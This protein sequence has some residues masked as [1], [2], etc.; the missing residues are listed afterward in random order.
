MPEVAIR[1]HIEPV[2]DGSFVATSPDVPGLVAE[3]RSI[4][5]AAAILKGLRAK[6]SKPALST[7][8]PFRPRWRPCLASPA[9]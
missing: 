2:E 6:L 4:T 5:E 1:L 7:A 9:R 8:I 3:G